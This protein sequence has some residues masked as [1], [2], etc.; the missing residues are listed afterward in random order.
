MKK[1][2]SLI[3]VLG[4][5][6]AS[7]PALAKTIWVKQKTN[8][9]ST[10]ALFSDYQPVRQSGWT[11]FKYGIKRKDG[12]IEERMA[13]TPYCLGNKVKLNDSALNFSSG[14]K[15]LPI[16]NWAQGAESEQIGILSPKADPST[17]SSPGWIVS[18][19]KGVVKV[20]ANSPGS[21]QVLETVCSLS[22]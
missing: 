6:V 17:L 2:T 9:G 15:G 10:L 13:A 21:K 20:N 1:L 8:D 14:G 16:P 19:S 18:T 3:T 7:S 22:N 11:V 5:V 4:V 12:S